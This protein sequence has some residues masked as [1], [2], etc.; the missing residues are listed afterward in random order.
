[1]N[2]G[3][4]V[5]RIPGILTATH[6]VPDHAVRFQLVQVTLP[7]RRAWLDWL[8]TEKGGKV[9]RW[10]DG[11]AQPWPRPQNAQHDESPTLTPT[12]GKRNR[13][14]RIFN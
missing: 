12:T 6:V 10:E 13:W 14:K 8:G 4:P 1:M 11:K 7:H 3:V 5:S 9:G 2:I